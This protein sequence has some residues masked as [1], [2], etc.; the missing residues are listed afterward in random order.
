MAGVYIIQN[1]LFPEYIKIGYVSGKTKSPSKRIKIFNTACPVDYVA[2]D[3]FEFP[4]DAEAQN[5]EAGVHKMLSI[6]RFNREYFHIAALVDAERHLL[7]A[8]NSKHLLH[9]KPIQPP[10]RLRMPKSGFPPEWV[11]Q[12]RELF[13]KENPRYRAVVFSN[14]KVL[15]V[16]GGVLGTPTSLSAL[17]K[18]YKGGKGN[19]NGF[20]YWADCRTG[21]PLR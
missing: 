13:F 14:N 20:L 1:P 6:Y 8:P 18:L 4:T 7:S 21:L 2:L 12:R 10:T 11:Y 9:K 19:Y 5:I 17:T 15:E 3:F 16:K